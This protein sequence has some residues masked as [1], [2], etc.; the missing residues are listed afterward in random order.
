MNI[1][2]FRLC[3]CNG[4]AHLKSRVHRSET[5]KSLQYLEKTIPLQ[6]SLLMYS[7]VQM[8]CFAQGSCDFRATL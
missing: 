3:L 4:A 5:K 7:S 6:E 2:V 1:S 8:W